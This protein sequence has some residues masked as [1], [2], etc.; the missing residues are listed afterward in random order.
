MSSEDGESFDQ[1]KVAESDVILSNDPAFVPYT[2]YDPNSEAAIK[3][4]EKVLSL[5]GFRINVK[6]SG[7]QLAT[8]ADAA[9]SSPE[10]QLVHKS[11]ALT[12][13]PFYFFFYGSLQIPHVVTTVVRGGGE[14][15]SY[16]PI[17]KP[18]SIEGWKIMMWGPYPAL[19]PKK[20]GKVTGKYW[21]CKRPEDVCRL[22]MYE[23]DAYRMEFCDI[24]TEEG[25]V[26]N[27]GRIFVS[28]VERDELEVGS[29]N[30]E[31][32]I[33]DRA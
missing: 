9:Q 30:L 20:G 29:F 22:C 26:I 8:L 12:F 3:H 23:T 21:K 16:K 14:G 24:T 5:Y 2:G 13:E 27:G 33:R 18:G 15:A 32:F 31:K 19:V 25:D 28:T 7:L 17:L 11:P 4:N 6:L 10:N 1:G